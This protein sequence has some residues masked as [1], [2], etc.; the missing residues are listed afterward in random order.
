MRPSPIRPRIFT[1]ERQRNE[2]AVSCLDSQHG[3]NIFH[4][5]TCSGLYSNCS[6]CFHSALF[7]TLWEHVWVFQ[8]FCLYLIEFT[9]SS[10]TWKVWNGLRTWTLITVMIYIEKRQSMVNNHWLMSDQK[11]PGQGL[12][13]LDSRHPCL[14]CNVSVMMTDKMHFSR[15]LKQPNPTLEP[16]VCICGRG[17]QRV[18]LLWGPRELWTVKDTD[19]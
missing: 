17:L 7:M 9:S 14:M 5:V 13:C 15:K 8:Y 1:Q 3:E 11:E 10:Q 6:Q 16:H 12:R 4:F 19:V 18:C 2:S